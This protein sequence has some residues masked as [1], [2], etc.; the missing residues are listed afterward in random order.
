[1][2]GGMFAISAQTYAQAP[3][4][5]AIIN[6]QMSKTWKDNEIKPAEPASDD[7]F[8]RR[9]FIDLLGRIPTPEEIRDYERDKQPNSAKRS[10][11]VNRLLHKPTYKVMG[12]DKKMVTFEYE[13]EFAQHWAEIWT[14]WL[15]S[16][17]GVHQMYHDNLRF[18]LESEYAKTSPNHEE[19][20]R[21]LLTAN[22][23]TNDNGA[24][25]FIGAHLGEPI[26]NPRDRTQNPADVQKEDGKFDMVPLT[27]RI[28]R[29]FLGVQTQCTQCHDHPFNPEMGQDSFWGVNAFLRQIDR[30]ITPAMMAG[31]GKAKKGMDARPFSIIDNPMLNSAAPVYYERR[32][33][34]LVAIPPTFLVNLA[35]LEKEKNERA[36]KLMPKAGNKTRREVLADYVVNHDNFAKAFIS[37]MWGHFFGR[38]LGSLP[39]FDDFGN[40][41]NK[42][43]HPEM[44]ER[45]AQE[46]VKYKYD[47][48][49]VMEW[50]CNS[51]VYNMSY[52]AADKAMANPEK[53]MFFTHMPL[54]SP[55]PEVLFESLMTATKGEAAA[56]KEARKDKRDA[57]MTKLVRQFGDD[58]GNEMSFNGTIVQAL[59][60]MNGNE[61]ND[62]IQRKDGT[63]AR[64][65]AKYERLGTQQMEKAVIDEIY[66]AAL[67][68]RPSSTTKLTFEKVSP[69]GL[70][71]KKPLMDKASELDFIHKQLTWSK[72][73]NPEFGKDPKKG[74]KMFFEDL[75]WTLL[76]TNEFILTH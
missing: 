17:G 24:A 19:I 39:A 64:A 65:M 47:P 25:A 23:K 46:F 28:T 41:D 54:R 63:V 27:S 69:T 8:I 76:N 11:L 4:Q 5:T 44:L 35:D 52:V 22:G 68:R 55:S 12:E 21:K 26:I 13:R 56:D 72:A 10:A 74:Y 15:M 67:G 49:Q 58:E 31:P 73:N 57:W 43:V 36:K 70:K 34:L 20:V 75:F 14:V 9:V 37:R 16:R 32:N 18:W 30:D 45:L 48:K 66:L 71:T 61:L 60:M 51:E 50:I 3:I 40:R 1:L 53:D 7:M 59:L 38:G 33:G 62:E 2:A 29:M 42:M 6:E